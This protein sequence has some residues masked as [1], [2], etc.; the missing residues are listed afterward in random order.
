MWSGQFVVI[1]LLGAKQHE[2]MIPTKFQIFLTT[3]AI[4]SNFLLYNI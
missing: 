3:L 1:F 4:F 2:R